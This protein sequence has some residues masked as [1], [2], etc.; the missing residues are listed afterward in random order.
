MHSMTTSQ[1]WTAAHSYLCRQDWTSARRLLE[2]LAKRT[3]NRDYLAPATSYGA[4]G[5][6]AAV[7]DARISVCNRQA[8]RCEGM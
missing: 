3:D 6:M 1:T 2:D 5:Q 4:T 7:L 8:A